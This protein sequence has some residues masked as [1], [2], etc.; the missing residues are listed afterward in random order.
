[1]GSK[2]MRRL[3]VAVPLFTVLFFIVSLTGNVLI[4]DPTFSSL[5]FAQ[6]GKDK[7][8]DNDEKNELKGNKRLREAV[9]EL[10]TTTVDLQDQINTIELLE[11]PKGDTGPAGPTGATGPQG[12]VGATGPQGVAGATGPQ[13]ATGSA[14]ADG[15]DGATGATGPQGPQGTTGSAGADGADGAT[16]ATGP[17]G[18]QGTTGSAGADGTDGATGAT[19]PQG[20]QGTT[21]S[22]GA[23]GTDGA[24]GA[25]GPQGPQGDTGPA[26]ADGISASCSVADDGKG[27]AILTCPDGTTAS[28]V[29]NWDGF[30]DSIL[31]SEAEGD[32]INAWLGTPDQGWLLCYRRSTDGTSTSTFH[33]QCDNKGAT[34]TIITL[35]NGK[36]IG[37][38]AA[39]QWN[40]TGYTGNSSN[41]LFS[42][43]NN[44]KHI[45][46]GTNTGPYYQYSHLS[47]GP[48]FGGGHDFYTNLGSSSS[49]TYCNFGFTYQ[50][51]VGAFGSTTCRNDFCGEYRPTLADVEVFYKGN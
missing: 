21:G 49:S 2:I 24:T 22:A 26:G 50:C 51:R 12:V 3:P 28:L 35:T 1:M 25:T 33:S 41:F 43:T 39:S 11:G 34:V 8:D 38:Y 23:D 48:T 45:P 17:Q 4:A 16:G 32:Q 42:L 47:F 7:K 6:K 37:G 14:G 18:P 31:A 10:Q 20:P 30:L 40:H 46:P 5:A 15:T 9:S 19:G 13:G 36:K 29:A 44:F 27:T